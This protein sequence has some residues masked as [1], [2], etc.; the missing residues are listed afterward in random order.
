M[1]VVQGLYKKEIKEQ[2]PEI[3]N[4]WR[5][6][7]PG[8]FRLDSGRYPIRDLWQRAGGVWQQLLEEA[9]AE[10]GKEPM[11]G[12]K[13]SLVTGHNGINQAMLAKAL[14]LSEEAFRKFEFPNCGVAEVVWNPGEDK[15]RMWRWIYPTPSVWRS[16]ED[17]AAELARKRAADAENSETDSDSVNSSVASSPCMD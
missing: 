7:S 14:G 11:L 16:V 17:T 10:G 2:W 1:Y 8:D 9:A 6:D 3:Y 15:A 12:T 5:G 4:Q 13:S